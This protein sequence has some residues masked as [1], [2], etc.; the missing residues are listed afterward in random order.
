[1]VIM[2]QVGLSRLTCNVMFAETILLGQ[3]ICSQTCQSPIVMTIAHLT[4]PTVV[5]V[6]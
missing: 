1:M 6:L 2:A 4:V 5:G 3:L